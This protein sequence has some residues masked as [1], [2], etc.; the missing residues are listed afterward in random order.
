MANFETIKQDVKDFGHKNNACSE[1]Y[2]RV[3]NSNDIHELSNVIKDNFNWC[4]QFIEDFSSLLEK[5]KDIFCEEKIFINTSI[6]EGFLLAWGNAT[7]EASGNA[8]VEAWGNATVEAWGNATV[9][10][11]G[12]AT[13][14]AS[15]N[16]TVRAWDNATVRASGNATVEA[17]DNATVRAW[18]NAT[19]RA[20][21]NAYILAITTIECNLGGNAIMRCMWNNAI[22]HNSKDLTF[23]EQNNGNK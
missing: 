20:W 12:N 17:S 1:Q 16:A 5:Y 15:G 10:A 13:V 21:D 23:K 14:E 8:T 22:I 6:E 18:D 7:V 3:I 2:R 19:V 11:S 4:C 9:E